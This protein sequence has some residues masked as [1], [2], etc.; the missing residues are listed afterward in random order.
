MAR[1]WLTARRI[2][3]PG[4]I[5]EDD[6]G[7]GEGCGVGERD[8]GAGHAEARGDFGGTA[9]KAQGGPAREFADD[10]DLQPSDAETDA[11]A[12]GLGACFLGSEAGGKTFI[13]FALAP[14]V[15]L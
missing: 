4:S 14:A 2:I 15:G 1:R 6:A 10:F 5:F 3:G 11:G 12:E 8:G 13:R 9:V 7:L